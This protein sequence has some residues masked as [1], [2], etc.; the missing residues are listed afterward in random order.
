MEVELVVDAGAEIGESPLWD[1]SLGELFW[2]DILAG[3]LHRFDPRTGANRSRNVGQPLGA[4]ALRHDGDLLLA[5]RD[6]FAVLGADDGMR[7]L[8]E[9]EANNPTM[10]MNDGACDSRGRF[11]AGTTEVGRALGAGSLYRL[12]GSNSVHRVLGGVTL[13]NGIDWSPDGQTMYYIDSASGCV[14]AFDFEV[15]RGAISRRRHLV[16]IPAAAGMPDGLTVDVDGFL[17]VALYRGGALR[18]Y[19]PEGQLDRI[20][21]LPVSLVTS[22]AFGDSDLQSLYVTSASRGLDR[23][24]RS[25][26]PMAGGLFRLLPGISGVA[27]HRFGQPSS[28]QVPREFYGQSRPD[29]PR[30]VP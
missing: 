27:P 28:P 19:S 17:W 30:S 11:W 21:E 24:S 2:V 4:I 9:V 14:D 26:E 7:M 5:V 1:A 12:D 25:R 22:C 23:D 15:E 29:A 3:L 18:R 6:G 20:V 16:E 8:V 10:R 13:S